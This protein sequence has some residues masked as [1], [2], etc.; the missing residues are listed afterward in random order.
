MGE[1][2]YQASQRGNLDTVKSLVDNGAEVN[3]I[4]EVRSSCL[5]FIELEWD[6]TG[7]H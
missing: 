2:L 5:Q 3:W 6:L 7:I 1:N 4:H